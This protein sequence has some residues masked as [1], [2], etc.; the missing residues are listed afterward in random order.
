MKGNELKKVRN[1]HTGRGITIKSHTRAITR[2]IRRIVEA[3]TRKL[4]EQLSCTPKDETST[5]LT[6]R[7]SGLATEE[8]G[9]T[10]IFS[11]SK[12]IVGALRSE[13]EQIC[14]CEW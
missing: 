5:M 12:D 3:L 4:T 9:A 7:E 14:G 6:L 1:L 10:I 13:K 8:T 2:Y 11:E